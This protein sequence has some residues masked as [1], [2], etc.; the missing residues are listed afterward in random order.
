MAKFKKEKAEPEVLFLRVL[1]LLIG[2][3]VKDKLGWKSTFTHGLKKNTNYTH[4][5]AFIYL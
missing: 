5:E 3:D 1:S 2:V 4:N